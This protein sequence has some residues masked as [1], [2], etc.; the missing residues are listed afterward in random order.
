MQLY[1]FSPI[2]NE[3]GLLEV[4]RYL[5][6]SCHK[7]YKQS[8]NTYLPIAGNVGIFC[9]Y[10]EEYVLLTNLRKELAERS[11]NPNQ[12]YF[13]LHEPITIP[14]ED[15]IPEAIYT[16]L[17]IRRPDPYRSQVGDVDF[18]IDEKGYTRLKTNLLNNEEI[19]GVRVFDRP[20]LDMIE[21]YNPDIDALAYVSPPEMTET[22]RTKRSDFTKL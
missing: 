22:V 13:K 10:N 11:E 8:L 2:S 17:Y 15:D 16:H 18:V 19:R 4:I 3:E 5:H 21:L 1:R 6:I 12:K 20:D 14:E 9:H 7:L